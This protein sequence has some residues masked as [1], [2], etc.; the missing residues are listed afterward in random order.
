MISGK[1]TKYQVNALAGEKFLIVRAKVKGS[2]E[3]LEFSGKGVFLMVKPWDYE[4]YIEVQSIDCIQETQVCLMSYTKDAGDNDVQYRVGSNPAF[5]TLLFSVPVYVKEP[6]R[7][8]FADAVV[9]LS[10]CGGQ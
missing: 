5:L 10:G 8:R 6:L 7:L 1:L 4:F 9:E 2:T 3:D